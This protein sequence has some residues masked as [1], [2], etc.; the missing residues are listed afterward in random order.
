MLY[1]YL[2][3]Q[4]TLLIFLLSVVCL[5]HTSQFV[6]YFYLSF[7]ELSGLNCIKFEKVIAAL[8]VYF[9]YPTNC[10]ISKWQCTRWRESKVVSKFLTFQ[11]PCKI[12]QIGHVWV[13]F[14][15][16]T[17]IPTADEAIERARTLGSTAVKY[18]GFAL[19]SVLVLL[20][21]PAY[22][23]FALCCLL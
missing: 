5:H 12:W 3:M 7:S 1:C 4:V 9:R 18:K 8:Q 11:S 15:S 14:S 21:M 6:A 13:N 17:K 20:I 23:V 19:G 16:S 22:V 10:C 2:K